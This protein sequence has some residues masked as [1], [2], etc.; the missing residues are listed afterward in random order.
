MQ[1]VAHNGHWQPMYDLA[2]GCAIRVDINSCQ[3]VWMV[4]PIKPS[5]Q[6][7]WQVQQLLSRATIVSFQRG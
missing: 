5:V 1:F 3:I 7:C 6:D 2:E 4:G